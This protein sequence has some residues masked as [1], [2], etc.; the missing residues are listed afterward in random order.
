LIFSAF[1][2]YFYLPAG[3]AV[4]EAGKRDFASGSFGKEAGLPKPKNFLFI[5]DFKIGRP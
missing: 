2:S 1:L 5:F 3:A 4:P